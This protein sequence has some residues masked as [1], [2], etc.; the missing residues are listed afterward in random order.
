MTRAR[1][2]LVVLGALLALA[3]FAPVANAVTF[4]N[5]NSIEIRDKTGGESG[6]ASP[7][8]SPIT[9]TGVPGGVTSI[10]VT[11]HELTH[12]FLDDVAVVL[13]SPSPA[14]RTLLLMNRIGPNA[15]GPNDGV[16]DLDLTFAD[17]GSLLP[18]DAV[19]DPVSDPYRPTNQQA[20]GAPGLDP[21]PVPGPGAVYGNPGPGAGGSATLAGVF[22]GGPANGTWKLYVIDT[23]SGDVGDIGAGWTLD[24]TAD[25]DATAPD[26]EI[27][28]GPTGT[29]QQ[30]SASFTFS[31]VDPE[32][33]GSF[34]CSLDGGEWA[35]CASPRHL[36]G[37]ADGPHT[38]R[39]RALDAA[40]NRDDTPA[41][42]T[43]T[44]DAPDPPE[45]TTAPSA[46]IDKVKVKRTSRTAKVSFSGSD[47]VTPA[48]ELA[49]TCKLD[50]KAPKPCTS[51]AK[52][53]RLKPGKHTIQ[54]TAMDAAGNESAPAV[55]TFKV[56]KRR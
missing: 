54:V 24:V 33:G 25:G 47:D 29:I 18:A 35:A 37:L 27:L 53:K 12:T 8:P 46:S 42:G 15:E 45:D 21:F 52:F 26:T 14:D 48:S 32:P 50:G 38:F 9:V 13:E 20:A 56:K 31:T 4:T 5:P 17:G 28:T 23:Q 1:K 10:S 49:F 36:N 30:T 19:P 41:Q 16:T 6:T 55:K 3:L 22:G 44:V 39:V 43:F 40:Q 7:Y 51:P 11:L 2:S 34:E